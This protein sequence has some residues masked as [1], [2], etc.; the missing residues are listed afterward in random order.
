MEEGTKYDDSMYFRALADGVPGALD[1]IDKVFGP[2]ID[3]YIRH[4][5]T[6]DVSA[7]DSTHADLL[8]KLWEQRH[9]IIEKEN[10]VKW[11]FGI[12]HKLAL[13]SLERGRWYFVQ[14]EENHF[15]EHTETVEDLVLGK[16]LE[17]R[18]RIA[19]KQLP[20]MERKVFLLKLDTQLSNEEIAQRL[21]ISRQTV[22]NELYRARRKI[23]Q[24]L[25]YCFVYIVLEIFKN[26]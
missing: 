11:M 4:F 18:V 1:R 8:V 14:L 16:E 24:L 7:V 9:Q 25:G 10:P 15:V 26:S 21:G 17:V 19:A 12:A 2:A 22:K 5:I 3:V 20:P 13:K 6:D 23:E